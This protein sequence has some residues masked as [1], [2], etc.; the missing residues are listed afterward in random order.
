M[1]LGAD[2]G[3]KIC[4]FLTF[5]INQIISG[6][7]STA[8]GFLNNTTSQGDSPAKKGVYNFS[9]FV[10]HFISVTSISFQAVRRLQSVVPVV[11]RQIRTC[12]DEEFKIFG[13]NTQIVS[14]LLNISLNFFICYIIAVEYCWHFTRL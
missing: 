11:I 14:L 13:I 12:P 2:F 8:G 10:M 4:V 6:N 9:L 1:W 7:D 5:N 3:N